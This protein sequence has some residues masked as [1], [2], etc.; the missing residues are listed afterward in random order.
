MTAKPP[1]EGTIWEWRAFGKLNQESRSRIVALPV[2][3]GLIDHPDEDVYLVSPTSDQNVKLRKLGGAW[4]I[5][6]KELLEKSSD[7]MELYR[8]S[9]A[10][11][12]EFPVC[13]STLVAAAGL[14]DAELPPA[15]LPLKKYDRQDLIEVLADSTPPIPVVEVPKVRSQ[16]V[17]EGGWVELAEAIFPQCKIQTVSIHSFVKRDV[18]RNLK[19][20]DP[21]GD[22]IV[23]NYIDACRRWGA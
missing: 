6:F 15:G 12:F 18:E 8:E 19:L 21:Q 4:V 9:Q 22:L 20:I 3:S 17:V 16:F 10:T 11:I 14:L 13:Q 23:M 5:K 7:S 1:E 2:R